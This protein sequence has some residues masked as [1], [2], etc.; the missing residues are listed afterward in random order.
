M[1]QSIFRK[2]WLFKDSHN[3]PTLYRN[4]RGCLKTEKIEKSRNGN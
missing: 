1:P 4:S 3:N 2:L